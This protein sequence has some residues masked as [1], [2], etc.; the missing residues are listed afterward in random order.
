MCPKLFQM[1]NLRVQAHSKNNVCWTQNTV[2]QIMD[3]RSVIHT[4]RVSSARMTCAWQ[5]NQRDVN[6]CQ[7][8]LACLHALYLHSKAFVS[9]SSFY[10]RG[11]NFL[12][13]LDPLRTLSLRIGFACSLG[14]G[15]LGYSCSSVLL[16]VTSA[17]LS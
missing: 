11:T 2:L 7:L 14:T 12:A 5:I 1:T 17:I 16:T 3:N 13:G 4:G 10:A 8:V 9:V 15:F 6:T